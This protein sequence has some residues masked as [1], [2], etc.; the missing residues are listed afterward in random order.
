M[1]TRS[2]EVHVTP[3][4]LVSHTIVRIQGEQDGDIT[5][6]HACSPATRLRVQW[7]ELLMT[8]L[9]AQAVQGV[10]E[11]FCAARAAVTLIP[12]QIPAPPPIA[13][14]PF[15]VPTVAIDWIR[16][17]AYAVVPRQELSR[18]RARQ[19]RWLDLHLGPVTFQILDQ[20]GAVSAVD[21]LTKAHR[22]ATQVFLDGP[23]FAADPR[24]QDYPPQQG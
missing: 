22:T 13:A 18:D 24:D 21:L 15:A 14:E 12:R 23:D 11:G 5:V 6:S 19:I 20:N 9:S 16:R 2:S 3:A 17:P 10:L 4:A 7:G 8:M 1:K